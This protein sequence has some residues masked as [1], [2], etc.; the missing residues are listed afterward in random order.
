MFFDTTRKKSGITSAHG[1]LP[2]VREKCHPL[3][4]HPDDVKLSM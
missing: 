3:Q 1:T 4:V 2:P